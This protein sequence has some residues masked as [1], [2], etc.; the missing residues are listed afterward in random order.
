M[1]LDILTIG[2]CA[3]D[4]YMRIS[5]DSTMTAADRKGFPEICFYHG[6]KVPVDA[7]ETSI[8]GNALNIA[9]GASKLGLHAGIY[10]ELGKDGNSQ[11]IISELKGFGVETG[12][13]VENANTPTNVHAVI[14]YG[15]DRTI[16]S[17]HEPRQ[18]KVGIWEK[19]K[20]IY[21]TSLGPNFE[22]F[23]KELVE[24][25]GKNPEIGVAFN[26][27]T[28]HLREGLES[29]KD[30]LK[31]TD[32]LFVNKEE[33]IKLTQDAGFSYEDLHKKLQLLGPKLT[34]ITDGANG[35]TAF[36][37]T[38]MLRTGIYSDSRA[39]VDK[40]GAGDAFAS[41]FLSALFYKKS[42]R[43]ALNWGVVNA[44]SKIKAVGA[45]RGILTKEELEKLVSKL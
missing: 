5:T 8:A 41:G 37:G 18:Y 24:Y 36:D 15:V 45:I 25:V 7:F 20:W 32:V 42:L 26:P 6:S 35:A 44:G 34:V 17:Y 43:E 1:A 22:E 4:Q 14:V 29:I 13:C 12:Y 30:V 19:P 9:V 39:E 16:F 27:G 2:D 40:T 38:T 21:Y 33:A 11:R 31:I 23:Q 10:T 28:L 3:I